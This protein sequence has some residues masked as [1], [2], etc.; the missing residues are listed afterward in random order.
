MIEV[1]VDAATIAATRLAASPAHEM[2]CLLRLVS[3]RRCHPVLGDPGPAARWVM[4][5]RDVRLLAALIPRRRDAY[6]PDFLTPRPDSAAADQ[7]LADQVDAIAAADPDAVQHQLA[8]RS[9]HQVRVV[10]DVARAADDGSL[11][12][13]AARAVQILWR[14]AKA[15]LWPR[16]AVATQ[17]DIA[18]RS[19]TIATSG[20]GAALGR[21]HPAISWHGSTIRIDKPYDERLQLRLTTLVLAPSVLGWPRTTAQLCDPDAAVVTYPVASPG[22]SGAPTGPASSST[23]ALIGRSRTA[24]LRHLS[25][26]RTTTELSARLGLAPSTVSHHL[27]VLHRAGLVTRRRASRGVLYLRSNRGG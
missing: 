11:P 26:E 5:D 23:A 14:A 15:D 10:A 18:E 20:V 2:V 13:R 1:D 24:I 8:D 4:R 12:L 22:R 19:S 9:G 6:V 21:L 7:A 27:G 17:A 16:I 3:A 25:T